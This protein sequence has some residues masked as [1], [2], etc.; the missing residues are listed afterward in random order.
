MRGPHTCGER[1]ARDRF[2]AVLEKKC[3][4]TAGW[5][6]GIGERSVVGLIIENG[7]EGLV[8]RLIE[9]VN[10][11]LEIV[12]REIR[13]EAGLPSGIGGAAVLIRR[14][15]EIRRRAGVVRGIVVIERR[16]RQ[17]QFR[18]ERMYPGEVQDGVGLLIAAAQP[19]AW[20]LR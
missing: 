17:K 10:A 6:L 9:R 18:V 4:E 1:Q 5:V 19:D 15:R 20:K 13:V 11:R 12:L 14:D 2:E 3:R 8:I 7:S 16:N